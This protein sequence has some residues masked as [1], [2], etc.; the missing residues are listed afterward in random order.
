[1]DTELD[2]AATEQAVGSR[3]PPVQAVLPTK[4]GTRELGAPWCGVWLPVEGV[5]LWLDVNDPRV[6]AEVGR[7]VVDRRCRFLIG[8]LTAVAPWAGRRGPRA[9]VA[10]AAV[11]LVS[12]LAGERFVGL[13]AKGIAQ[14]GDRCV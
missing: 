5:D 2:R 9:Y 6:V 1:M 11:V 14:V 4:R 12:A 13:V 10:M 7:D 3:C 8:V